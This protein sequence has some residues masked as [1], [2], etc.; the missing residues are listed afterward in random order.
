MNGT[1]KW[2]KKSKKMGKNLLG[3]LPC[4]GGICKSSEGSARKKN[5]SNVEIKEGPGLLSRKW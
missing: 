5:E 1:A 4:K 2:M 3:K